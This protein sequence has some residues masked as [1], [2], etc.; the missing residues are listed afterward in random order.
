[1]PIG[2]G[3]DDAVSQ[4]VSLRTNFLLNFTDLDTDAGTG[5]N[6]MP[7]LTFGVRF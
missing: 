2:V 1:M 7:G 4:S 3:F 6:V 5:A